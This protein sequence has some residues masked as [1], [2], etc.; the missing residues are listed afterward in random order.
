MIN[1][2]E[3]YFTQKQTSEFQPVKIA[4]RASDIHFEIYTA[5]GVFSQ[6]R[7]DLGS[8]LL[9]KSATIKKGAK[10]L[11]LGCGYGAVGIAIKKKHPSTEIVMSDI[12]ERA[13]ALALMNIKLNKIEAVVLQS[14]GFKNPKLDAMKFDTILLNPPQSAGKETCHA[15]IDGSRNHLSEGGLLQIVARH[16]KG[17]KTLG[18]YMESS[19]GNMHDVAKSAGYRVYVSEKH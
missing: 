6:T 15:L 10:V 5:G 19:F 17:G 14:D 13:V 2:T 1:M 4:V 8:A 11:D 3:H 16:N 7:I 18:E 9:I 12:N